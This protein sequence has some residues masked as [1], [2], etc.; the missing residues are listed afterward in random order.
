M[1]SIGLAL[2]TD[3]ALRLLNIADLTVVGAYAL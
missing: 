1:A 2:A 3:V